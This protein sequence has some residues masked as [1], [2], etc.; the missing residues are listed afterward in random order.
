MSQVAWPCRTRSVGGLT[1]A[2]N[3]RNKVDGSLTA[4]LGGGSDREL[5]AT[6]QCADLYTVLVL[7]HFGRLLGLTQPRL[8]QAV[9]DLLD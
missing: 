2:I 3:E 4:C 7:C 5:S 1:F 9:D 8:A 6:G